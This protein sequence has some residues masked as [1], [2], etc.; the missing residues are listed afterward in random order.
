MIAMAYQA[1]LAS[2]MWPPELQYIIRP[3]GAVLSNDGSIRP[4][5]WV[6][7]IRSSLNF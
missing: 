7:A 1:Q 2:W 4:N 3:G 6:V 5:A